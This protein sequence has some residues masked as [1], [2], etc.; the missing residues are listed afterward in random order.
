MRSSAALL[1]PPRR[2]SLL[3][4]VAEV[5]L[6]MAIPFLAIKGYH[7]LLE[8][9]AGIVVDQPSPDDPGW[10]ASVDPTPIHGV[11]EVVDDRLTGLTLIVGRGPSTTGSVI[12]VPA[13]V[14]V[15]GTAVDELGPEQAVGAVARALRLDL[16]ETTVL[17]ETSW[18][19]VLGPTS[20][21]V[22]NPDP[23]PGPDGQT[24]LPV[25][26]VEVT[27]EATPAFLG[28]PIVGAPVYSTLTRR[29]RF[30]ASVVDAP[31][32]SDHPLGR[33]LRETFSHR[34]GQV[35]ELPTVTGPGSA[36]AEFAIDAAATE[37]LIRTT[38]AFPAGF[39][40]RDRLQLRIIDRAG[41]LPI[42]EIA[43]ELAGQGV[44]VVQIGRALRFDDG[45]S[46]IIVPPDMF[47]VES[48]GEVIESGGRF[49]LD[50]LAASLGITPLVD[51][52]AE[53]GSPVTLLAGAGFSVDQVVLE[54]VG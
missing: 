4:I 6:I 3:F 40:G 17:D 27:A 15:D 18:P 31:P 35:L 50:R 22:D 36:T 7:T 52:D 41:G 32:A 30:W 54:P 48:S 43:A 37:Q 21:V 47:D 19:Q 44:E 34:G 28:R 24:L 14:V 26:E 8:S 39:D 10:T 20:Y 13:T 2:V 25:G 5:A 11:A 45:A 42:T 9:R 51:P 29:H 12:L 23:V 38:V 46:E 16:V 53:S 1:T 49:Q 33:H